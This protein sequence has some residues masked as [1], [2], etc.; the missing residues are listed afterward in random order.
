VSRWTK[1]G[2][3]TLIAALV[4]SIISMVVN[5]S[6]RATVNGVPVTKPLNPFPPLVLIL[7]AIGALL[8]LVG[9]LA[10][11]PQPPAPTPPV[12]PPAPQP[13]PPAGWYPDPDVPGGKRFWDGTNWTDQP[14][15]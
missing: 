7:L 1:Y 6:T 8:I 12:Q 4:I 15:P 3:R 5:A 10:G 13:L 11:K 2:I 9:L 14:A